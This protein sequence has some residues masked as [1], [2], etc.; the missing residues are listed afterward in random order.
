[1]GVVMGRAVRRTNEKWYAAGVK[2]GTIIMGVT[3][4]GPLSP[5]EML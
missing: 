3:K 5:K 4:R 1:M 2:A